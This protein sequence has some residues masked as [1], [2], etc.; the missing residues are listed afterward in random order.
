MGHCSECGREVEEPF[1][2]CIPCAKEMEKKREERYRR[3]A[4]H[5]EPDGSEYL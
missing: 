5:M 4:P 1:D 3:D 2:L